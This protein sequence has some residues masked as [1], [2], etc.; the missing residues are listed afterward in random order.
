M[1]KV[2]YVGKAKEKKIKICYANGLQKREGVKYWKE[3]F[4]LLSDQL[5][6]KSKVSQETECTLS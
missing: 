2:V 5:D 1:L 3:C 6:F 4:I